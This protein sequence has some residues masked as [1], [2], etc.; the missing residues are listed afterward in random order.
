MVFFI[1]LKNKN[2]LGLAKELFYSTYLFLLEGHALLLESRF[3]FI[4]FI[5]N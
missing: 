2:F 3:I 4:S 1:Y 5:Q